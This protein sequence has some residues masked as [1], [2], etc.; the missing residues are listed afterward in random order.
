MSPFEAVKSLKTKYTVVIMRGV[1]GS[2]KSTI[3]KHIAKTV[4]VDDVK[5]LSTDDYFINKDGV[6][7]FDRTKL[8]AA[9]A[10]CKRRFAEAI[11]HP[12]HWMLIVDNTNLSLRDMAVYTS[13]A[14]TKGW[15]TLI[16]S[17]EPPA[18]LTRNVHGV[19]EAVVSAK[20]KLQELSEPEVVRL[21]SGYLRVTQAQVEDAHISL[22]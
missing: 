15:H 19:P 9:H 14:S 7:V 5:I 20:I 1:M 11:L 17:V 22:L 8:G 10:D 3:A 21:Y 13:V 16:V 12:R 2:G 18:D 6:Y 4:G